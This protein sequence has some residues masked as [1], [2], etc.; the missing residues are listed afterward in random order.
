MSDTHQDEV[1][2]VRE[3]DVERERREA[4]ERAYQDVSLRAVELLANA[5][6]AAD[7]A[8]AEAQSYARDLE[9]SARDQYRVI[10]QRANEA[11]RSAAGGAAD[12]TAG[13]VGDG[14]GAGHA[15][16]GAAAASA[17]EAQQLDYVRTYARVAHTQ[18]GAVLGALNVELDKLAELAQTGGVAAP[19][20]P[21]PAPAEGEASAPAPEVTAGGEPTAA[22]A[23]LDGHQVRRRSRPPRR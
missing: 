2:D 14:A 20:A 13:S 3:D 4:R 19:D 11:A 9:E 8:V 17:L 5:Q 1:V 12:R 23:G 16:P 21:M 22:G 15:P 7:E 10:L 6:R 18:L